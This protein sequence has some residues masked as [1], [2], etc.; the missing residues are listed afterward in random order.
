MK[1]IIDEEKLLSL[2]PHGSGIDFK[3]DI[4]THKN[5]NITVKNAFHAMNEYGF[6]DGIM[7]FSVRIFRIKKPVTNTLKN[8]QT[9][10]LFRKN[11]IDFS[12][13]CN[14]ERKRT[15]YGLR[16]YLLD[17]I[18]YS[19]RSILSPMRTEII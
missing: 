19:L 16:E 2:L 5:G 15:F 6:Y 8:G 7:S 14:E 11:D 13:N 3:W 18:S 12:L 9:Q 10:I 17:T 1:P 4:V